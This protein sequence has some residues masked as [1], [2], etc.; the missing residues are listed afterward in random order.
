VQREGFEMK[1]NRRGLKMKEYLA[2]K[3][4]VS[5]E[6]RIMI[7]MLNVDEG[8]TYLFITLMKKEGN[9]STRV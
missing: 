7:D 1:E 4:Y 6:K 5:E 9:S 3:V 2:D 8:S